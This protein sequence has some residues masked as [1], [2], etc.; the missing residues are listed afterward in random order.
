M[1]VLLFL[2]RKMFT[3][4]ASRSPCIAGSVHLPLIGAFGAVPGFGQWGTP[5]G[6][7]TQQ[8]PSSATPSP[9]TM[10]DNAWDVCVYDI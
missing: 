2:H 7:Q 8:V 10:H 4:N 3:L 9:D 1:G 6:A 5:T